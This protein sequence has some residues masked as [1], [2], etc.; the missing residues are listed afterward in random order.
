MIRIVKRIILFNL[1]LIISACASYDFKSR[2]QHN[3]NVDDIAKTARKA[4]EKKF[5]VN[6]SHVT[7]EFA[8]EYRLNRLV[9]QSAYKEYKAMIN[10]PF[11]AR[12]LSEVAS[13]DSSSYVLGRYKDNVK[14]IYINPE[15]LDNAYSYDLKNL[16]VARQI[17]LALFIHEFIHAADYEKFSDE[18]KSAGYLPGQSELLGTLLEGNAEYL[19][20]KL[21]VDYNCEEGYEIIDKGSKEKKQN[22]D[23]DESSKSRKLSKLFK[24][25]LKFKYRLGKKY[26]KDKYQKSEGVD[27]IPRSLSELGD[28]QMII[29]YPDNEKLINND[30][31]SASQLL[32][33]IKTIQ[34]ELSN[35]EYIY[36]YEVFSPPRLKALI[37]SYSGINL[38]MSN[39]TTPPYFQAVTLKLFNLADENYYEFDGY[40]Y[41]VILLDM[42]VETTSQEFMEKISKGWGNNSSKKDISGISAQKNTSL[43]YIS[44][45]KTM[46]TKLDNYALFVIANKG[47]FDESL[48]MKLSEN[49]LS[50]L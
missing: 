20:E 49:I 44:Q 17:Y 2:Y 40:S 23:N 12:L 35:E 7:W 22:N 28:S 31:K 3:V 10:H 45:D 21:C 27:P 4:V 33:G 32:D 39:D 34:S 1:I 41:L 38:I 16:K 13:A 37:K 46:I 5:N 26:I 29:L 11:Y 18:M 30:Y 25:E 42:G 43:R 47:K 6:L 19:T 9:Y 24:Q 50:S 36:H 8:D 15:E 14:K 48:M